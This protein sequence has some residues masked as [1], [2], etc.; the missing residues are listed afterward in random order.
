LLSG[1]SPI[2][3]TK[4]ATNI[5]FSEVTLHEPLGLFRSVALAW[6]EGLNAW[7]SYLWLGFQAMVVPVGISSLGRIM[8]A[9][10]SAIDPFLGSAVFGG[11]SRFG[12][13]VV[14]KLET[15]VFMSSQL[16][17]FSLSCWHHHWLETVHLGLMSCLVPTQGSDA[18]SLTTN[19]PKA[20]DAFSRVDTALL[21]QPN[22]ATSV[23]SSTRQQGGFEACWS[24]AVLWS[25]L[26][27]A[28]SVLRTQDAGNTL[29]SSLVLHLAP[30]S[31]LG[32]QGLLGIHQ[33]LSKSSPLDRL[34]FHGQR[35]RSNCCLQ[36]ASRCWTCRHPTKRAAKLGFL[37]VL[38]LA[39]LS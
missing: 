22:L 32:R 9:V 33:A 3:I 35:V 39:K 34:N 30:M 36:L 7:A 25:S 13:C 28:Q 29:S 12:A 15:G 16:T 5:V 26:L 19:A 2:S 18:A 31:F 8:N 27:L 20:L 38:A 14:Q 21:I 37:A 23:Q 17:A 11:L 1:V 24:L 6:T 10:D 4:T